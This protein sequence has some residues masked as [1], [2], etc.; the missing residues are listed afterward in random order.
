MKFPKRPE[1]HVTEAQSWRLLQRLAP[2]KEWIVRE[3]SER[4]YGIDAY[5]ELVSKSGDITGELM[6]VQLKA[7]HKIE[8]KRPDGGGRVAKSPAVKTTTAAYWLR[9]PVPV[10]L[11]V[12]DLSAKNIYFVPVQEQIRKHF[13]LVES[14]KTITFPLLERLDLTSKLGLD[15]FHWLYKRERWHDQ[16]AFHITNLINQ[17]EMF[18]EFIRMNQNRDVFLEVEI[19]RHLQFRAL[20]EACRL[21]AIYLDQEWTVE[22]L[23]DLYK[24]DYEEWKDNFTYLHEKTLDSALQGIEKLFP[25]LVRQA[26]ELVTDIQSSYWQHNDP[27]FFN[28]CGSGELKWILKGLDNEVGR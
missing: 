26:I 6:S 12:A 14:Q 13:D 4:D 10:F 20:Y 16:F 28:L 8:W 25:A 11:F 5:I 22:S 24:R 19:D 2:K 7:E 9:L 27:M 17:V 3:V 23:E 21:A 1:A 15:S 18:G